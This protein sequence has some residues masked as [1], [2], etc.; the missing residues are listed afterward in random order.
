[1][2]R[3]FSIDPTPRDDAPKTSHQLSSHSTVPAANLAKKAE[4]TTI[5]VLSDEYSKTGGDHIVAEQTRASY[6]AN[7]TDPEALKEIA[8]K[9]VNV[10]PLEVSPAN[11]EV[12]KYTVEKD[13]HSE[14]GVEKTVTSKRASPMK[15]RSRESI[16]QRWEKEKL[17]SERRKGVGD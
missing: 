10:N 6:D 4:R 9:G 7:E 12:S 8:G 3:S 5:T 13:E 15:G 16:Q 17:E 2:Y 14:A 1:L 11:I